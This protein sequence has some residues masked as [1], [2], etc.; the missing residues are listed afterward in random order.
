MCNP[1]IIFLVQN[2]TLNLN[3]KLLPLVNIVRHNIFNGFACS[4]REIIKTTN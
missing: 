3:T 4:E 1:L 2:Y